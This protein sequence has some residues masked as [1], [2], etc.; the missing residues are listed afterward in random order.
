MLIKLC[1]WAY[2]NNITGTFMFPKNDEVFL[3]F[4]KMNELEDR[5]IGRDYLWA[6]LTCLSGASWCTS[7]VEGI[8]QGTVLPLRK[9]S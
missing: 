1:W 4:F 7:S 5:V 9:I 3:L 6:I 2:F 8:G